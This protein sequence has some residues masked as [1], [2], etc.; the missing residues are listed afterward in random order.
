V[1]G[2][3]VGGDGCVDRRAGP[4]LGRATAVRMPLGGWSD[5][6]RSAASGHNG[7]DHAVPGVVG[8]LVDLLGQDR[9]DQP[10]HGSAVGED[11]HDVGAPADLLPDFRS[12]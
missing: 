10:D 9:A 7:V 6:S 3:D 11:P 2:I 8:P 12:S 5:R 4:I 1:R